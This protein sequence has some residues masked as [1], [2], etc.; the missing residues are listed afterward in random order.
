MTSIKIKFRPSVVPGKEGSIYFQIIHNRIVR[1]LNTEYKIH[2]DEWDADA[3]T[4]IVN[5]S[6][7]NH[8]LAVREQLEWDAARLE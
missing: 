8:L 4:V 5:G 1:Q 7:T 3:E 6:R 2:E